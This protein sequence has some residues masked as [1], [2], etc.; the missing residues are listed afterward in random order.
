MVKLGRVDIYTEVGMMS[1]CL[2]MSRNG[3]LDAL[4]HVCA[5][6]KKNHNVE[7]VFDPTEPEVD[8]KDFLQEE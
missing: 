7:M 1:S 5:Y 6:L 8:M 2:A 4:F 3:H